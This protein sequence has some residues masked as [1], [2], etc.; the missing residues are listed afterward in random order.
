MFQLQKR[1][2][3]W[4]SSLIYFLR[5]YGGLVPTLCRTLKLELFQVVN[6]MHRYTL[7]P[8]RGCAS[9]YSFRRVYNALAVLL[10][11]NILIVQLSYDLY[12]CPGCL[13]LLCFDLVIMP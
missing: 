8:W 11:G 5:V 9:S 7:D 4:V 13:P 1:H 10:V 6:R 12:G 2:E 3:S